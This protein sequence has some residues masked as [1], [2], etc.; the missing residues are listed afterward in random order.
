MPQLFFIAYYYMQHGIVCQ[1]KN[2]SERCKKEK[3]ACHT[4][5]PENT[6]YDVI[7]L[8]YLILMETSTSGAFK[9]WLAV[10]RF[11]AKLASNRRVKRIAPPEVKNDPAYAELRRKN[12]MVAARR[13][14]EIRRARV[15]VQVEPVLVPLPESQIVELCSMARELGLLRIASELEVLARVPSE[16]YPTLRN[17]VRQNCFRFHAKSINI[18]QLFRERLAR[19]RALALEIHAH[20]A[21]QTCASIQAILARGIPPRAVC[22]S[23]FSDALPN[24][25]PDLVLPSELT[26]PPFSDVLIPDASESAVTPAMPNPAAHTGLP[27]SY[28]DFLPD[29]HSPATC[30]GSLPE[31]TTC[32]E[33]SPTTCFGSLPDLVFD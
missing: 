8:V 23:L 11:D 20:V 6:V 3:H 22:A 7:C 13:R 25:L 4:P 18:E 15:E 33:S 30:F 1:V 14:A 28:L 27:D 10:T 2:D 16:W 29:L 26:L 17:P 9:A 32:F 19:A 31:L 5:Q 12:T 24:A 21:R